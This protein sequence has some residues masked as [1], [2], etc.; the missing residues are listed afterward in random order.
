MKFKPKYF[1]RNKS[2]TSPCVI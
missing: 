1:T 2:H